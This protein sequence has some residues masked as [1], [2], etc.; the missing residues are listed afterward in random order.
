LYQIWRFAASSLSAIAFAANPAIHRGSPNV[1][2]IG[3]RAFATANLYA[4]GATLPAL[5][6]N[7][8]NPPTGSNGPVKAAAGSA[9]YCAFSFANNIVVSYCLTGSGEGKESL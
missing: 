2:Y 6:Y 5:G 8:I 9:Y 1:R 3:A 7:G 4:G